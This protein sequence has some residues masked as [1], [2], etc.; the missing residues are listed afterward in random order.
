METCV[1]LGR[2]T[3]KTSGVNYLKQAIS[4]DGNLLWYDGHV[5]W[6]SNVKSHLS[7]QKIE[8]KCRPCGQLSNILS[9]S[10][11][12]CGHVMAVLSDS[13]LTVWRL[14]EDCQK[15]EKLVEERD[16]TRPTCC[17]WHQIKP[18]VAVLSAEGLT[19]YEIKSDSCVPVCRLG[20]HAINGIACC[21][22]WVSDCAM[23]LACERDVYKL[24]LPF[25]GE[26]AEKHNEP[27]CHL[28]LSL[29]ARIRSIVSISA[30]L[31]A[32]ATDL[33]LDL[34]N[35]VEAEDLFE[36]PG[37]KQPDGDRHVPETQALTL[38]SQR[39][40]SSLL[41]FKRKLL[42]DNAALLHVIGV[43]NDSSR[44]LCRS[45]MAGVITPDLLCCDQQAKHVIAGS[46]T[47]RI[48][49]IFSLCH[50]PHGTELEQVRKIE[51]GL[52]DRPKGLWWNSTVGTVVLVGKLT[53]DPNCAFLPSSAQTEYE[54]TLG[55]IKTESHGDI[56]SQC[57]NAVEEPVS[58]DDESTIELT[59]LMLPS[60]RF[61]SGKHVTSQLVQEV[62]GDQSTSNGVSG[63]DLLSER[64]LL[65]AVLDEL[66]H[67][68]QLLSSQANKMVQ[69]E[70][71]LQ[72]CENRERKE[73]PLASQL[74][75]VH[76][77]VGCELNT[78]R[79]FLLIGKQLN[80]SVLQKTFGMGQIA[81]VVEGMP[82]VVLTAGGDGLIPVEFE[83]GSEIAIVEVTAK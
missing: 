73:L 3:L 59:D 4:I 24:S 7:Q 6:L 34:S 41:H 47:F 8:S 72:R 37:F 25:N 57:E 81:L 48:L 14:T 45:P 71:R 20:S 43:S 21:I 79:S 38:L 9:M 35:A 52:M 60:G 70:S 16:L 75:I 19:W 51:L 62:D 65:S 63:S 80:L 77:T 23:V 55:H 67:I 1:P 74:P 17:L 28:V 36:V 56:D 22:C 61:L 44:P 13:Q 76:V 2:S 83:P 32:V 68:R 12:S 11:S 29:K 49:Y 66:R 58:S 26:A 78:R 53:Q 54:L 82:S 31:V 5:L 42:S 50:S 40:Q 27:V 39:Q 33:Q 46:N 15:F 64:Q 18:I 30:D 10:W 69:M